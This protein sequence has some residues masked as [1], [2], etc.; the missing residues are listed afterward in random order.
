MGNETGRRQTHR[1]LVRANCLAILGVEL[2]LGSRFVDSAKSILARARLL[3][4]LLRATREEVATEDAEVAHEL[5][6]LPVREDERN[7]SAEVLHGRLAIILDLLTVDGKHFVRVLLCAIDVD[8]ARVPD[9][10][11]ED[12]IGV[13]LL[14]ELAESLEDVV[15]VVDKPLALG[16]KGVGVG[17][18]VVGE[19]CED[20]VDLVVGREAGLLDGGE[21]AVELELTVDI[22]LELL[23]VDGLGDGACGGVGADVLA[24][25]WERHGVVGS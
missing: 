1:S 20:S 10:V 19:V 4:S 12:L 25:L 22:A 14:D 9:E 18:G 15:G 5:A 24:C 11:L 23:A 17:E 7:E 16:G 21:D 13:L 6:H 2:V 8:I 3:R